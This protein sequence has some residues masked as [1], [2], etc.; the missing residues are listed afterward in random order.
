[1]RLRLTPSIANTIFALAGLLIALMAIVAAVNAVMSTRV[2]ARI[3]TVND[4]YVPVYGMLARAHIRSLEQSLALRQ[5]ALARLA[6]APDKALALMESERAAGAAVDAELSSAR[7]A[8]TRQAAS[9]EG[10]DDRLELGRL[11]AKLQRAVRD[12]ERYRALR[13]ETD[14]G[15]SGSD[16]AG[17]QAALDRI[18]T[19]RAELNAGL[20]EARADSL[21]FA[22]NAVQLTQETESGVIRLTL[23]TLA[24]AILLGALMASFVTR[25]LIGSIGRLLAA[26]E[27]AEQGHYDSDLPV[28][29][30]DEIG[31]LSRAFN[32]MLSELRL[33]ARIQDT[34]GRYVDPKVV[35]GLID[36]PEL[37][38]SAG[39]RRVMTV[40]FADMRGFTRL[41]EDVTPASLVTLLNRYLTV[42]TEEVRAHHGIVDKYIGDAV[43]SF[44]GPPFVDAKE[45]ALFACEAALAQTKRF[46]AFQAEMPELLGYRRFTPEVGLRIGVATGEVIVGNVGSEVAM[47]YTVMG[48]AVNVAARLESLNKEYGTVILVSEATARL[49]AADMMMREVDRVVV[50]GRKEP[51]CVFEVLCRTDDAGD[52]VLG[53]ISHY[54]AGLA[55]YRARRWVEAGTAFAGCLA[56]RPLDGPAAVMAA[57]V[58]AYAEAPPPKDWDQTW[59]AASK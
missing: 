57:R 22:R 18:D 17:Q 43:M 38:G 55:A 2:G 28:T 39:D 48:D 11:D 35:K 32:Q 58:A 4:T 40:A 36:K 8:L 37:T 19:L 16:P 52:D 42:L 50:S 33:K 7:A 41:S 5:A 29:S 24:I 30:H 26:T 1:M 12:R 54:A 23:V 15:L 9:P 3:E 53:L 49:V 59:A 27:A 25:R 31:R 10:F 13:A 44:W 14:A 34:F 47:N 6:G 46:I 56:L 45:Q 21:A 20:E 51:V